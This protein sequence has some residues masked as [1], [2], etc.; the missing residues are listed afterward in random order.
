MTTS[1]LQAYLVEATSKKL[2]TKIHCTTC[3]AKAFR[4]GVLNALAES[5]GQPSKAAYDQEACVEVA[6]ALSTLSP[7]GTSQREVADAVR[8]ILADICTGIPLLDME[9]G[10]LFADSWAGEILRKMLEHH[11]AVQATRRAKEEYDSPASVQARREE[12]KRI[13]QENHARRLELKKERDRIWHENNR[14]V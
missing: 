3:G 9:V 7:D 11:E 13:K 12:E 10:R 2:C 5:T 8:C 14:K 4:L 6:R 1:W